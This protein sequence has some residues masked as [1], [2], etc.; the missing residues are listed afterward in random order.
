MVKHRGYFRQRYCSVQHCNGRYTTLHI[1]QSLQNVRG[2][3]GSSAGKKSTCNCRNPWFD[4]WVRNFPWRR[5]R[6][7]TPA[8][9]GFPGGPDSKESACSVEDL[10]SIPVLGRSPGGGKGYPVLYSCL[11]NLHGQRSLVGCS[12][13]GHQESDTTERWS[14]AHHRLQGSG[15]G[16]LSGG[17]YSVYHLAHYF[18]FFNKKCK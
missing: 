18:F 6:L 3:P 17:D 14:T 13:W 16:H 5:D 9:L 8:F 15:C 7:P 1:W 2:F 12:P 11:E 10:G 4:S